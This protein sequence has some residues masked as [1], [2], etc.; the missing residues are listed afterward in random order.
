MEKLERQGNAGGAGADDHE[1]RLEFL[2]I[3]E[4]V[5]IGQHDRV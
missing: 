2:A 3:Y 5:Q 1:I 4:R